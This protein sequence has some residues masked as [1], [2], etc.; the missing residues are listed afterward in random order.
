MTSFKV[1]EPVRRQVLLAILLT[2]LAPLLLMGGEA[3][4][5]TPSHPITQT[6]YKYLGTHAGQCWTFMQQVVL[7]ATGR[8]V[9]TNYRLGFFEAGAV[10][11]TAAEAQEGDIIQIANDANTLPWASYPGLHTA[12]ITRNLG[13][14]RFDAIDS[15]QNWDEMVRLRP[16]YDPY[17]AAARYGLQ[18]H[19]YRI[20]LGGAAPTAPAVPVNFETGSAAVVDAGADCLNLRSAPSVAG[21]RIAC[22]SS[23][24]TVN[25]I[26]E[27]V[28][29]DGWTWAKVRTAAGEGWMA[30]NYLQLSSAPSTVAA[31]TP[32]L[33]PAAAPPAVIPESPATARTDKSPGCLRVRATAGLDGAILDCLSAGTVV[34]VLGDEPVA[35]GGYTWLRVTI[36]GRVTGWVASEFLIR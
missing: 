24:T 17:G 35:A 18:V 28:T 1:L 8:R 13:G 5:E 36:A 11:V 10:E 3:K 15:N 26:G 4:A 7:E 2:G 25:V 34:T 27:S 22:L 29:A 6:A 19:I 21:G 14:G 30:A 23:G 32:T 12:I 20:P 16:N 33:A 31:S 9:G